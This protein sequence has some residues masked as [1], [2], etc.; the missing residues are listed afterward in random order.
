MKKKKL[1]P[2]DAI[3]RFLDRGG[4]GGGTAFGASPKSFERRRM[5]RREKKR[6]EIRKRVL[7]AFAEHTHRE[8]NSRILESVSFGKNVR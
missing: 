1:S 7:C 5:R 2:A 8:R 4:D 6:E 3:E